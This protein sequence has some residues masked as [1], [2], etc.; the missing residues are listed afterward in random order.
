MFVYIARMSGCHLDWVSPLNEKYTPCTL[1]EQVLAYNEYLM[2]SVN[3]P[4]AKLAEKTGCLA[5]C[6]YKEFIFMQKNKE[7]VTWK[8]NWSSSFFLEAEKTMVKHEEELW[9]FDF[10][11]TLNG[12]GGAMGLFLGWS[13]LNILSSCSSGTWRAL[14]RLSYEITNKNKVKMTS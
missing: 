5:R 3:T 6:K 13:L 14:Q 11:D 2:F 12:I 1:R 4:L 8:H 7:E 10:D 9:A